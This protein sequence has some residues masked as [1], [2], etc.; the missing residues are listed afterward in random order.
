MAAY[1]IAHTSDPVFQCPPLA[2]GH[3]QWVLKT[4]SVWEHEVDYID[5]L[6]A[7]DVRNNSAWNQRFYVLSHTLDLKDR[8]VVSREIDYALTHIARA[9]GNTS[10]WAFLKGLAEPIG[11]ATFPQV[12]VHPSHHPVAA[13]H[14]NLR[15]PFTPHRVHSSH[16]PVNTQAHQDH[17]LTTGARCV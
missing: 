4:Y 15:V 13:L 6:L 5:S 12:Q 14:A 10:P 3:R 11:Y 8:E 17:T 9:P 7:T 2:G 1:R 16:H